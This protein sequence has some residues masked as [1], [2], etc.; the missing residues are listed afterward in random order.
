MIPA[1]QLPFPVS[2]ASNPGKAG[3]NN[4]DRY[5]LEAFF[6]REDEK[7]NSLLAIVA[8]GIGAQRAGQVAA[9]LAVETIARA[10]GQSDASQPT[11]ILQ[12]AIVQASQAVL[13]RSEARKEWKGM[14]SACLCAW[15]IGDRLY[16]ASV[17]NSRLYLLRGRHLHQLNTLRHS[18]RD[19]SELAKPKPKRGRKAEEE[20]PL[21]GY[22][23]SKTPV[24]VDMKLAFSTSGQ[25]RASIENQGLRLLPNDRLLLCTD[26]IGDA[27]KPDEIVEILGARELSDAAPALAQFALEKGTP[28]NLTA[29]VIGLPPAR[30]P[31]A[32]Q[33]I[34][35]RRAFA[36]VLLFIVLVILGL[37][38]WWVWISQLSPLSHPTPTAIHTLTP[39]PSNT[40]VQ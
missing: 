3:K 13:Y 16:A 34:N 35:W 20:D 29:L 5:R 25:G 31:L 9:A 39:I 15:I 37:F 28:D 2:E 21:R 4:E 1:E 12:A 24:E 7:V 6:T 33:P 11:G 40:P 26:G 17:G 30:P 18:A 22:L 8:D 10:V 32:P 38:A 36:S 27:L 14:G 23:G 19:L